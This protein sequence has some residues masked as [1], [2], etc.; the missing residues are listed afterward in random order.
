[1]ATM[2]EKRVVLH[3]VKGLGQEFTL[4]DGLD[5]DGN[6]WVY[7]RLSGNDRC[8]FCGAPVSDGW[9]RLNGGEVVCARHTTVT[10]KMQG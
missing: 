7:H 1:M 9:T 2:D 10:G 6:V 3:D 5:Q 4:L 8:A